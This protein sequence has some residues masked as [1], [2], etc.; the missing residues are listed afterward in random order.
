MTSSDTQELCIAA[1]LLSCVSTV[2]TL[3][4]VPRSPGGVVLRQG[5]SHQ[6][7]RP[8]LRG[9]RPSSPGGSTLHVAEPGGETGQY[10]MC[11]VFIIKIGFCKANNLLE[12]SD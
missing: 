4:L 7:V 6:R 11:A 5:R 8:Q 1:V 9:A 2:L 3:S 12:Y 10:T